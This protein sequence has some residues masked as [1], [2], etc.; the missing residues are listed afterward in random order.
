[1]LFTLKASRN[2]LHL[3]VES[4]HSEDSTSLLELCYMTLAD[5]MQWTGS[6]VS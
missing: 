3:V 4:L 5:E 1:M 2:Q 6:T